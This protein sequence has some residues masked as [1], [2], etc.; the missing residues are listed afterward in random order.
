MWP[1]KCCTAP[2]W[3]VCKQESCQEQKSAPI[4]FS[5]MF[6]TAP[7][8]RTISHLLVCYNAKAHIMCFVWLIAGKTWMNWDLHLKH[9]EMQSSSWKIAIWIMSAV[10]VA[11]LFLPYFLQILC[12]LRSLYATALYLI[13]CKRCWILNLAER[14]LWWAPFIGRAPSIPSKS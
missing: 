11:L 2:A 12:S 7:D 5:G 13:W 3:Q 14:W 1:V 6:S 9:S 4:L 8:L 10:L